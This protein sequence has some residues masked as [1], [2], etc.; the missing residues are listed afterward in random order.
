VIPTTSSDVGANSGCEAA[1]FASSN[2]IVWL[3]GSG[4]PAA[5]WLGVTPTFTTPVGCGGGST[6]LLIAMVV[7]CY[8]VELPGLDKYET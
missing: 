4:P 3:P 2:A 1:H 6:E 8:S 7:G 5:F